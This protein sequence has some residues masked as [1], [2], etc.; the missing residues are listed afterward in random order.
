MGN[1][2]VMT[3]ESLASRTRL[4]IVTRQMHSHNLPRCALLGMEDRLHDATHLATT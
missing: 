1:W 3:V 2:Q 4:P